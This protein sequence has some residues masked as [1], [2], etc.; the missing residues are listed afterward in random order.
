MYFPSLPAIKSALFIGTTVAL[1]TPYGFAED[2]N[3]CPNIAN[4]QARLACYDT[5]FA[6]P[7]IDSTTDIEDISAAGVTTVDKK[8]FRYRIFDKD[9]AI[10]PHKA[11][12]LLPYTYSERTNTEPFNPLQE[13]L[14]S[15]QTFDQEEVKFQI[16]FKIPLAQNLFVKDATLWAGYSQVSLWQMYNSDA[17]APFR[18]TNYEPELFWQLS[19]NYDLLGITLDSVTFG[20]N[21]QSNG[22]GQPLSRSWNRLFGQV[23]F[24]HNRWSFALKPWYR[25][26]ENK[27]DDDN[28]DIDDY[29]GYADYSASYQWRSDLILTGNLRNN[30]NRKNHSSINLGLIFPIPGPLNGY[31]EYVN[32]YGES[33]IDYNHRTKRIGIGFILNEWK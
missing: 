26:P 28:P 15:N 31:L 8:K 10:Q 23:E 14:D 22:R 24:S 30:F 9:F 33:L 32:G 25:I 18:E 5:L 21:H 13:S 19:T 16:S 4:D 29:L 2:T 17:S 20:F 1:I 7:T 3:E 11:S 27:M 12:Y 6:T